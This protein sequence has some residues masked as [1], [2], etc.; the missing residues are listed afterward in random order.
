MPCWLDPHSVSAGVGVGVGRGAWGSPA[1][2]CLHVGPDLCWVSAHTQKRGP[3]HSLPCSCLSALLLG[4]LWP[5]ESATP[6]RDILLPLDTA[7]WCLYSGNLAIPRGTIRRGGTKCS[8][9]IADGRTGRDGVPEQRVWVELEGRPRTRW[10]RMSLMSH[11]SREV[12]PPTLRGP[13]GPL[14]PLTGSGVS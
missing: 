2:P 13:S 3:R 7:G 6:L 9:R 5:Q 4:T 11:T 10:L 8:L 12:T 1:H 14:R